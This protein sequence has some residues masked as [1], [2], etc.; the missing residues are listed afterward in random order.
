MT[1]KLVKALACVAALVAAVMLGLGVLEW[2][3]VM[4]QNEYLGYLL[5]FVWAMLTG[6][7]LL[8]AYIAWAFIMPEGGLTVRVRADK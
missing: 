6:S 3:G 2:T 8:N 4:G 7:V 1:A 5:L